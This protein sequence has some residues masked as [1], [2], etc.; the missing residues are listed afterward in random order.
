MRMHAPTRAYIYAYATVCVPADA[1]PVGGADAAADAAV[2]GVADG[3][4]DE[5]ADAPADVAT[6]HRPPR[7]RSKPR[8]HHREPLVDARDRA[9]AT[10]PARPLD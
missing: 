1:A 5:P 8:H 4:A 9:A 6:H 7:G 10:A 2:D 3:V